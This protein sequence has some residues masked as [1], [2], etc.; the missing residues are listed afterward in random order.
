MLRQGKRNLFRIFSFGLVAILM[1]GMVLIPA[2]KTTADPTQVTVTDMNRPDSE[3]S[4]FTGPFS[5][6]TYTCSFIMPENGTLEL[7]Y[8]EIT[9]DT[10]QV[11]ITD[12][13]GKTYSLSNYYFCFAEEGTHEG[14]YITERHDF[15]TKLNKGQTYSLTFVS[16][17]ATHGI[18]FRLRYASNTATLKN[19]K[20]IYGGV[21][22][23]RESYY[24]IAVP[25]DG[26]LNVQLKDACKT[27][28]KYRVR[29]FNVKKQPITSSKEITNT[30]DFVPFGVKKGTYYLGVTA[31]SKTRVL[32]KI[33]ATTKALKTRAGT[34]K[35]NAL[36]LKRGKVTENVFY[37]GKKRSSQKHWYKFTVTKH[38]KV[39]LDISVN[40]LSAITVKVIP[41]NG[42]GFVKDTFFKGKAKTG[43]QLFSNGNK[44]KTL[45]PGVYYITVCSNSNGCGYYT[46]T[47]R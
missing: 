33:Q 20:A 1:L 7:I 38:Q 34:K 5:S 43:Y 2:E 29:L 26:C 23:G 35:A 39:K 42:R 30:N 40:S 31:E 22:K 21:I 14:V 18:S 19:G 9:G 25:K 12:S 36:A 37:A 32:Y 8:T 6:Y 10:M 44:G 13:S 47:W 16:G 24:R 27:G 17:S 41:A 46:L 28:L 15:Y 4:Y 45:D 11:I 3:K